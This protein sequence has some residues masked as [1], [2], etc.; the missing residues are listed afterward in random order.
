MPTLPGKSNTHPSALADSLHRGSPWTPNPTG[1]MKLYS[2]VSQDTSYTRTLLQNWKR[3]QI[4]LAHRKSTSKIR[5]AGNVS[6][7][8]EEDNT[9]PLKDLNEIEI[10]NLPDK[11]S[12]V[13][14]IKCS[15]NSEKDCL[16]T[17]WIS[18]ELETKQKLES[19]SEKHT[20]GFNSRLAE[21]EE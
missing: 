3:L 12:K 6:E 11:E 4:C 8:K 15:Q 16:N 5:K 1:Q 9:S 13:M 20:R 21:A 18:T 17:V 14:V 19:W 7:T 10:S 2:C